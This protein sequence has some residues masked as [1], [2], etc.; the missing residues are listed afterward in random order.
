[1]TDSLETPMAHGE[2][3]G[4]PFSAFKSRISGNRKASAQGKARPD[5]RQSSHSAQTIGIGSDNSV[6]AA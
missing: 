6:K 3:S 4:V 2:T 5:G 1:M